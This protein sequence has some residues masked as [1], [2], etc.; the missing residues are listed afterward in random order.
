MSLLKN[1]LKTQ[2]NS[3]QNP[4]LETIKTELKA[5]KDF[6]KAVYELKK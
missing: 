3:D 5:Y 6:Y 2:M 4:E 1:L